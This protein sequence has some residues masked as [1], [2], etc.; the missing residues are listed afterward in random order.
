MGITRHALERP[1]SFFKFLDDLIDLF[2]QA[3]WNTHVNAPM[4]PRIAPI[5]VATNILAPGP[6]CGAG[7]NWVL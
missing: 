7:A 4:P 3:Q 2:F 6:T 5:A 1:A